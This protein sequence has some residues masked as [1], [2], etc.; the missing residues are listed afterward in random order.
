MESSLRVSAPAFGLVCISTLCKEIK[1]NFKAVF[2]KMGSMEMF[3][4]VYKFSRWRN[5]GQAQFTHLRDE[6]TEIQRRDMN[7]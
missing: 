5:T 1:F 4:E 6:E 2:L 3:T 7:F